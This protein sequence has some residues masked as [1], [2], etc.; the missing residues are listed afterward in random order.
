M[1]NVIRNSMAEKYLITD[2]QLVDIQ[3][4]RKKG[5]HGDWDIHPVEI[6]TGYR[7]PEGYVSEMVDRV[8]WKLGY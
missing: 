3:V 2:T 6:M 1:R 7:Y 5:K 4:I 8:L